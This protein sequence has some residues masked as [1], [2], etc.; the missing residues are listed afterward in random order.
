MIGLWSLR[1]LGGALL[2]VVTVIAIPAGGMEVSGWLD[3]LLVLG[4]VPTQLTLDTDLSL[5]L[6]M[7]DILT[8][9]LLL[10]F[11]DG[12]L[13]RITLKQRRYFGRTLRLTG[14]LRFEDGGFDKAK[15]SL[16]YRASPW[17]A[18]CDG[19]LEAGEDPEGEIYL[20]YSPD[21]PPTYELTLTLKGYSPSLAGAKAVV[22]LPLAGDWLA[23]L[24]PSWKDSQVTF[25]WETRGSSPL[26]KLTLGGAGFS[27][28]RL[29]LETSSPGDK[30]REIQL[31]LDL[32]EG[33]L[34]AN[35]TSYLDREERWGRGIKLSLTRLMPLEISSVTA[36]AFGPGWRASL[37]VPEQAINFRSTLEITEEL[38]AFSDLS[39]SPEG[40]EGEL[41]FDVY[42]GNSSLTLG[43]ELEASAISDL[44]L[45]AYLEF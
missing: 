38:D 26:G 16:R 44:Y 4:G 7:D 15:L 22:K 36:Y 20:S 17:E 29:S 28:D 18:S 6:S 23:K 31:D 43:L 9:Y 3:S 39:L 25:G 1:G 19:T 34:D 45:E 11:E 21:T 40:I 27:L 8:S 32:G 13:S 30:R 42:Q 37:K 24:S 10:H 12:A 2:L 14:S 5:E 35:I 41:G 33:S